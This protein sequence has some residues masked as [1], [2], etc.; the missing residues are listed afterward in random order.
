MLEL[1]DSRT[2]FARQTSLDQAEANSADAY[3]FVPDLNNGQGAYVREDLF[4]DLPDDEWNA[5]MDIVGMDEPGMGRKGRARARKAEKRDV[6][7]EAKQKRIETRAAVRK[8]GAF[9]KTLTKIGGMV[10]LIPP[11][12]PAPFPMP[13]GTMLPPP[14][15]P[16][17]G[18]TKTLIYGGLAFLVLGGIVIAVMSARKR[19]RR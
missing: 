8:P 2:S 5:F 9:G 10:G 6:R 3:V 12:P 4:D 18:M 19:K 13:S 15:D 17:G 14:Q 7:R 16:G 1:A 11:P